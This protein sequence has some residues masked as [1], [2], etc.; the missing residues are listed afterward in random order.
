M[1]T[2]PRKLLHLH[3]QFLQHESAISYGIWYVF[4]I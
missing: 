4:I 1:E 3:S 2:S